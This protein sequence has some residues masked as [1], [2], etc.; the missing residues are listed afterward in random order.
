LDTKSLSF[1]AQ[2][3][4]IITVDGRIVLRGPVRSP[5]EKALIGDI[6]SQAALGGKVDNQLEIIQGTSSL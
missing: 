3:I 6:A 2:N 4:K 5:E 1:S